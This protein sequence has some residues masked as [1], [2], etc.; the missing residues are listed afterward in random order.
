MF[1]GEVGYE[2][3]GCGYNLSL[4]LRVNHEEDKLLGLINDLL[5]FLRRDQGNNTRWDYPEY[6]VQFHVQINNNIVRP[7]LIYNMK[8]Q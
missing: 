1:S 4:T 8:F 7:R 6:P 2:G 3:H 5:A